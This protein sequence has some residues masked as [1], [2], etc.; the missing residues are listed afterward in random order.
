MGDVP[1]ARRANNGVIQLKLRIIDL[2]L[3][4]IDPRQSRFLLTARAEVTLD[5]LID[6]VQITLGRQ[7]LGLEGLE[8]VLER[9]RVDTKQHIALFQRLVTL[10]RHLD[11]LTG[12]YRNHRHRHE[13]RTR[14][15][16]IRVVVVHGE[17]Q[18]A[19]DQHATEHGRGHCP[20]VQ[21]DAKNLEDRYTDR[22]IGQDQ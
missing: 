9:R 19:D 20:F 2:R 5:Q 13:V 4:I 16:R 10:Y 6:P 17:N 18:C 12:D 15:L 8:P 22:G 1:P 21:G 11:H 3:Q 7:L 14:H